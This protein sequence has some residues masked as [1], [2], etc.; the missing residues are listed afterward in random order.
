MRKFISFLCLAT[1]LQ[2]CVGLS[3][4]TFGTFERKYDLVEVS[5]KK[6]QF[7]E[8]SDQKKL[9]KEHLIS[10]WGEPDNTAQIGRCE[11]VTYYDGYNW[12]GVGALL[13]I[14]PLPILVPSGKEENRFYFID[15]RSVGTVSEFGELT[16]LFGYMCG[17][18]ECSWHF[19]AANKDKTRKA[20]IDWCG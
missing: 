3:V 1:L 19:G 17:S 16:S 4:G 20:K 15:G 10:L 2:G 6:N 18:N 14:V 9:T 8:T 5:N 7:F 13:G 12:S 11:V